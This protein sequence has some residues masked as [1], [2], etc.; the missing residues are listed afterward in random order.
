[1]TSLPV[2]WGRALRPGR[3]ETGIG[4]RLKFDE[5]QFGAER[6]HEDLI[7]I[8]EEHQQEAGGGGG[9]NEGGGSPT[10][11]STLTV[12]IVTGV[13]T[14][15]TGVKMTAV[16]N[17]GCSSSDQQVAPLRPTPSCFTRWPDVG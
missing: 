13:E 17:S 4:C 2:W 10:Q 15:V 6:R 14:G 1:M 11:S 8:S 16:V 12:E 5:S 7:F 3:Q 9:V